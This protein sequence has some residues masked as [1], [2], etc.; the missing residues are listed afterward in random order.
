MGNIADLYGGVFDTDREDAGTGFE[1]LP[2]AWYPVQIDGAEIKDTKAGTGKFLK[3]EFTVVGEK[4]AGRKVFPMITLVNPNEKAMEIGHRELAALG[5][6]CG[7][8]AMND[9]SELLG[10]IIQV[11]LKVVHDKQHGDD[12]EITAYKPLDGE[13]AASTEATTVP[14]TTAAP[15]TTAAP[16]TAKAPTKRP[17]EK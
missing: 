11:R 13:N 3:G 4:F 5:Q 16:A 8:A 2:P 1:P 6:A 12:N 7:L 10:K 9:T 15:V 14:A 17:W